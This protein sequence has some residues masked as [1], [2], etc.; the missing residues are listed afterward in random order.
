MLVL[1]SDGKSLQNVSVNKCS[2]VNFGYCLH[3]KL[4]LIVNNND[5]IV[6]VTKLMHC[7]IFKQDNYSTM[8]RDGGCRV[9]E[10]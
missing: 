5:L 10:V 1:R 2:N 9:G 3:M 6:L 4:Q 7:D 8:G